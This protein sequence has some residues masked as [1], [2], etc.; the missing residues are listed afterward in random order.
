MNVKRNNGKNPRQPVPGE[1]F[2]TS[3]GSYFLCVSND[4]GEMV[5]FTQHA[6]HYGLSLNDGRIAWGDD[7]V[8]IIPGSFVEE[9]S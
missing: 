8:E 2:V 6:K 9:L 3:G 5:L 1:V 7:D 4:I